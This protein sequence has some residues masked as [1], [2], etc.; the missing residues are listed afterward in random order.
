MLEKNKIY[1]GNALEVLKTFPDESIDCVMTSPPYWAL[2]DYGIAEQLGLEQTFQEYIFKLCE[3]FDEVKRVLKKEGTCFVNVGDTY[4]G[5]GKGAGVSDKSTLR[6]KPIG[7]HKKKRRLAKESWNFDKRPKTKDE[8]AKCLCQIPSRFAIEMV[9]RGWILRNEIIWYKPN[10]MPSSAS[11]RFTVDFEKLFFFVKNKHYYFEAQ[12]EPHK[13]ESIKRAC[14][15][16][17][18]NKLKEG[19]YAISYTGEHK[20]YGDMDYKLKT[21]QLRGVHQDGRNKRCVWEI[22]LTPFND[23]HFAVYPEELC[24][25]PIKAGCPEKG[26]VL[27]CFAG[28]STTG[29]VALKLMRYYVGIELNPEYVKLGY[30]RLEG[31][32]KQSNLTDFAHHEGELSLSVIQP[33]A[34]SR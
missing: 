26:I 4:R 23:S 19:E 1:Q 7:E 10:A 27:D 9:N 31:W 12:R 29:L 25:L 32:L 2:R 24:E 3:I 16:R 6:D 22:S 30:K 33:F 11:D 18:S 13:I 17:T 28:A 5:S 8:I 20:G 15:A 14:R 21:G 34:E